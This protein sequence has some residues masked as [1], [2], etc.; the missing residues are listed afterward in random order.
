MLIRADKNQVQKGFLESIK[1]NKKKVHERFLNLG[2]FTLSG[3]SK[4]IILLFD[5]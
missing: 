2:I 3:C 4:K 5:S 1:N